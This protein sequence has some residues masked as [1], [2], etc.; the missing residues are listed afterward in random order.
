MTG[1]RDWA[2]AMVR[3][4]FKHAPAPVK[5]QQSERARHYVQQEYRRLADPFFTKDG[6]RQGFR[7]QLA[8]EEPEVVLA[9]AR[10]GDRDALEI[11][12]D[13]VRRGIDM[14]NGFFAF[15]LEC[16]AD[17][18]PKVSPGT[19]AKDVFFRDQVIARLVNLVSEIYGLPIHRNAEHRGAEGGPIS[20]CQLVGEEVGLSEQRVERILAA[21]RRATD[22]P[23]TAFARFVM[24]HDGSG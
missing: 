2:W 8:A 4:L 19:K 6:N 11:L 5:Q 1:D 9:A 13:R 23:A 16:F 20:A 12:R 7:E 14:P 24:R 15:V 10:K 21:D 18:P 3:A 17:G 22:D